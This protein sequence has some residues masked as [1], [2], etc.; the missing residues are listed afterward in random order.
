MQFDI[1]IKRIIATPGISDK[2]VFII[3]GEIDD[4]DLELLKDY[5]SC[6]SIGTQGL[7]ELIQKEQ[8]TFVK[9]LS[10]NFSSFH[11]EYM[12]PF[13]PG[14]VT[15]QDVFNAYYLG[16]VTEKLMEKNVIGEYKYFVCRSAIS[17][18][19]NRLHSKRVFLVSSGLGN[20]KTMF[21]NILRNELRDKDIHVFTFKKI[22]IDIDD[23]IEHISSITNRPCI[24]IID[25]YYGHFDILNKFYQMGARNINFILTARTSINLMNFKKL[26]STLRIN[27]FVIQ[28]IFLDFLKKEDISA[29]ADVLKNNSLLS[30]KLENSDIYSIEKYLDE[31]CYRQF[32]NILLD[33]FESS[34]IEKRLEVLFLSISKCENEIIKDISIL[35]LMLATMNL[36]IDYY[37]ILD[38]FSVDYLALSRQDN[39]FI[40]EI[41][42][43]Q[44]DTLRIKSSITAKS[45]LHKI[46]SF[47]SKNY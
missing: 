17:I 45:L 14:S 6:E 41:F 4:M 13:T 38:L 36:E 11:Y 30:A 9:S 19:L 16:N 22:S 18:V 40:N 23:E 43:F 21:C 31:T 15:Y 42:D 33:M 39:E 47:E 32:S 10:R 24:V 28:P 3:G 34:D 20:G 37:D 8:E 12:N 27:D 46:I 26:S 29:L 35:S 25:N 5:A 2:V 44:N 7:S 1:D